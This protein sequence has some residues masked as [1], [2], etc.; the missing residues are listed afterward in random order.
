MVSAAIQQGKWNGYH[1]FP[2]FPDVTLL[3]VVN[4]APPPEHVARFRKTIFSVLLVQQ[5]HLLESHYY[6]TLPLCDN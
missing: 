4:R 3:G 6:S 1:F 5:S 2:F